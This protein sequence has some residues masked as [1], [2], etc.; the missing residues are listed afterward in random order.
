MTK[1]LS[2]RFFLRGAF[3]TAIAL[4]LM[5]FMLNDNGT[6]Y[7]AGGALPCRFVSFFVPTAILG[8]SSNG[9]SDR[10][11]PKQTGNGYDVPFCL[12]PLS[13]NGVK[14]DTSVVSGLFVPPFKG[15]GGYNGDYH[16][17][18][19]R[20]TFTGVSHGWQGEN[21]RVYGESIDTVVANAVGSQTKFASLVY[22]ADPTFGTYGSV[23]T[24]KEKSGGG[25][26]WT[27]PQT[28]PT[29]A[30]RALFTNFTPPTTGG[31]GGGGGG[32]TTPPDDIEQRLRISS[33]T[34]ARDEINKLK[35]R[36]GASDKA[37]LDQHL[38]NIRELEKRLAPTSTPSNP[39]NPTG[40][41]PNAFC[42]QISFPTSDPPKV[43]GTDDI[44]KRVQLFSDLIQ[45]A[46]ACDLT[47]SVSFAMSDK[48][49]GSG[50]VH[51]QWRNI[52]GLHSD[53][54]HSGT[55]SQLDDA[56]KLFIGMY[57]G[58]V[59]RLKDV[60]EGSG[61]ILDNS[62]VTM[63]M[64][65][66]KGGRE[67]DG[68][69]DPNHS[70]DNMVMLVAGRAGGLKAGQHIVAKDKHPAHVFNTALQALGISKNLGEISGT[71]PLI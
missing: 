37:R 61:T 41:G 33:L 16:E 24:H 35:A 56:N 51:P 70:T 55:Q 18:A 47:R 14:D 15:P 69:G 6:A 30:Y 46:F 32:S 23:S 52:G 4:P 42:K 44:D 60:S 39:S 28:S 58:I 10:F 36:L 1:K 17:Y 2:R 9:L 48:L 19:V 12:Q 40:G 54:Q 71:V 7:A 49:T 64:E 25:Y 63:T 29:A 59:K 21:W 31:G 50:M 45:V 65:G 26:W 57:A 20:S 53:V 62:V 67:A 11:T 34:Y 27:E 13:D 43:G 3:G 5:D 8:S 68:G 22:Q 66:G 38:T